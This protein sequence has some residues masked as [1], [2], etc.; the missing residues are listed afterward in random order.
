MQ[1]LS[2]GSIQLITMFLMTDKYGIASQAIVA[3]GSR[4]THQFIPIVGC[5]HAL[6]FKPPQFMTVIRIDCQQTIITLMKQAP[7]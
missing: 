2:R 5:Q 3:A 7:F 6:D 4:G 1:Q